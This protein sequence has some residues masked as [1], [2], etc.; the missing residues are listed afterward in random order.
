MLPDSVASRIWTASEKL[1]LYSNYYSAGVP[2]SVTLTTPQNMLPET[3][4]IQ[5]TPVTQFSLFLANRSSSRGIPK[6]AL[7]D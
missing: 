3:G 5:Y 7:W 6:T 2:D 4:M 1:S